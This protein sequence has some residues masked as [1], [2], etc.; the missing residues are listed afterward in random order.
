[1]TDTKERIL[2]CALE[3]FSES[4]YE[5]VSVGQ[6]A[7]AVGIKAPSLYK[8]YASKQEIFDALLAWMERQ[9]RSISVLALPDG[10]DRLAEFERIAEMTP[11]QYADM[12][13]RQLELVCFHPIISRTRKFLVIEQFRNPELCAQMQKHQYEDVLDYHRGL[14]RFLMDRGVLAGGDPE[15]LALQLA[16][17]ISLEIQQ[18]DR[19]PASFAEAQELIRR[20]VVAFFNAH[21][22]R[23]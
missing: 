23:G 22:P 16:A 12:V 4:G 3:L 17:P 2:R 7:A 15:I 5:A 13:C 9:Y 21:R 10:R 19:D 6:L 14:L 20:H 18:V 1:M 11:E 8:H